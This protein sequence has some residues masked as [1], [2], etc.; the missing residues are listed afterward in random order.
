MDGELLRFKKDIKYGLI[1]VETNGLNLSFQRTRCWQVGVTSAIGETVTL[2][3]ELWPMFPN[4]L[5]DFKVTKE[6]A[7][8]TR[9]TEE[10]HI[11]RAI[12]PEEAFEQFWPILEESDYIIMHNGLRFDIFLLKDY[13][14]YMGKPWKWI[15]PKVL[16]TN[17]L[18]KGHKL[19]IVYNRDKETLLEYQYKVSSII[20]KGV[21]TNL[22]ALGTEFK[23]PFDEN[24]LHSAA[25]DLKLNFAVW[26]KLKYM[27]EI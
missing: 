20:A 25:Y 19:G 22:K 15:L 14:K 16:D 3:K 9:Y 27:V 26:N 11:R 5:R 10:E 12:S 24:L 13:A 21:K 18:A 4:H 1:D 8:I 6:A 17:A 7:F 23:I 2:E